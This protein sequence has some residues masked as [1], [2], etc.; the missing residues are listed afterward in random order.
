[1]TYWILSADGRTYGPADEATLRR[2]IAEGRL[3]P[4][5]PVGASPDGP[6]SEARMIPAVSDLFVTAA[7]TGAHATATAATPPV[8]PTAAASQVPPGWPPNELAV[9]LLVSGIFHLVYGVSAFGSSCALGIT[10]MGLGC[11]CGVL[12]IPAIVL[13]LFEVMHYS[14]RTTMDPQRWLDRTKIFAIIDICCVLW[15]NIVAIVCGIVVLTQLDGARMR[16][17]GNPR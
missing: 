14:Q 11:C 2:W 6:W 1:M 8:G 13:G 16:L 12:G 4:E 15:G 17:G 10:T 7:P 9:P 3:T 5:T